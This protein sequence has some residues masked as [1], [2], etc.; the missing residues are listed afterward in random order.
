MCSYK[1]VY[2]VLCVNGTYGWICVLSD[3]NFVCEWYVCM[4]LC[5]GVNYVYYQILTLCVNG[6]YAW[7]CVLSDI[8]FV[9]EWYVCMGLC[10]IRY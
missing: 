10:I 7:V 4:G 8:N 3:I 9:C 2:N 1:Y 6:M 5:M